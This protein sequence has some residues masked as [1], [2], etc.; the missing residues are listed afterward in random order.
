[1][2]M[3]F[4]CQVSWKIGE[5]SPDPSPSFENCSPLGF[6]NPTS[7]GITSDPEFGPQRRQPSLMRYEKPHSS[8][9]LTSSIGPLH[10][11]HSIV[12]QR[13]QGIRAKDQVAS[14]VVLVVFVDVVDYFI[15]FKGPSDSAL[16]R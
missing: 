13:V 10:F 5:G 6:L 8:H 14:P 9:F 1:M 12:N 4:P 11:S 7:S 15:C 3:D 16:G 2:V